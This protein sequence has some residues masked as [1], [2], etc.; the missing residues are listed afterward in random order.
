MSDRATRAGQRVTRI[1]G[2]AV[3]MGVVCAAAYAEHHE[4][5]APT[6]TPGTAR[7]GG[8]SIGMT[9]AE[10]T[11]ALEA[12]GFRKSPNAERRYIDDT[13]EVKRRIRYRELPDPAG[14]LTI[15]QLDETAWYPATGFDPE[16][17]RAG[18]RKRFGE[19][20]RVHEPNVG[21][22][23]LIYSEIPD[24]PTIVEV[25]EACQAE[26][27]EKTPELVAEEA[28]KRA[29][30]ATQYEATN[31]RVEEVCPAALP[32]Y[33]KMADSLEAPRMVVV[34]RSG[35]VD[36]IVRWPRVEADL[37]RRVGREKANR[38]LKFGA[39]ALEEE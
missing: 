9:V 1:A 25:I 34:I 23:D 38:V 12:N 27:R 6:A 19:P 15:Y 3:A 22:L 13:S 36:T 30:A 7:F 2:L 32:L 17:H 24:A 5:A 37:V 26:I 21:R 4:K 10:A 39:E 29:S 16:V 28:E 14:A 20:L 35:R 8:V 33:R 11:W 31:D 18:M